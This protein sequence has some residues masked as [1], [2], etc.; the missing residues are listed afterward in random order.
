[1]DQS[2][3][4]SDRLIRIIRIRGGGVEF[5]RIPCDHFRRET[6]FEAAARSR[7]NSIFATTDT[8]RQRSWC[9][10]FLRFQTMQFETV[11]RHLVLCS[12]VGRSGEYPGLKH[13]KCSGRSRSSEYCRGI[14]QGTAAILLSLPGCCSGVLRAGTIREASATRWSADDGLGIYASTRTALPVSDMKPNNDPRILELNAPP[15]AMSF[16]DLVAFPFGP[17]TAVGRYAGERCHAQ[18]A[19]FSKLD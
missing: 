15:G 7:L 11:S 18:S 1:M 9:R 19:P 4:G 14:Y 3:F 16:R 10:L 13:Q 8:L 2:R 5:R 12:V 17:C 6:I